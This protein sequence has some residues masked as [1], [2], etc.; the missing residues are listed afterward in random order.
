MNWGIGT[1]LAGASGGRMGGL[2]GR[3]FW[4]VAFGRG[5]VGVMEP[6]RLYNPSGTAFGGLLVWMICCLGL[7]VR[8]LGAFGGCG[9]CPT[10]FLIVDLNI[11]IRA[12]LC[13]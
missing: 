12:L 13:F 6:T 8:L 5:A 10:V 2:G 1:R 3:L 7:L 11:S 9:V 4:V